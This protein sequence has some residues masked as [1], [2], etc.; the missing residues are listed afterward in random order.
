[1]EIKLAVID[2]D[3]VILNSEPYHYYV[4][5]KLIDKYCNGLKYDLNASIGKS[6]PAFYSDLL[7][8]TNALKTDDV[9]ASILATMHFNMVFNH[10]VGHSVKANEGVANFLCKLHARGIRTAVASSSHSE[11]ISNCLNYL[12]L[13]DQIDWICC[14]NEVIHSKP[15]PEIYERVLTLSGFSPT[16]AVAVEDSISGIAA[17]NG[18]GI[19]CFG[20]LA[21]NEEDRQLNGCY[22][23]VKSFEEIIPYLY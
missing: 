4:R 20:Y 21:K 17:A 2:F 13:A 22:H 16:E 18:A 7:D 12:C 1:M 10:I 8:S 3:G 14:G 11:Y 23:T 9:N 6:V 19:R 15:N 5:Q